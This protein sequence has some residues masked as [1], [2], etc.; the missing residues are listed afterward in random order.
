MLHNVVTNVNMLQHKVAIKML[1]LLDLQ[2]DLVDN[3]SELFLFCED[4][5]EKIP[6]GTLKKDTCPKK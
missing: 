1:M 3:S 2:F 4:F 5:E 6:S